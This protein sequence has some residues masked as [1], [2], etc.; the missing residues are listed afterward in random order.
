MLDHCGLEFQQSCLEFDK[1]VRAVRTASSEQVRQPIRQQGL[2]LW[3]N[4]SN[5]LNPLRKS[6]GE[7]T[8]DKFSDWIELD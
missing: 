3:K 6:L 5:H 4:Y 8:L 2:D 1:N 7:R